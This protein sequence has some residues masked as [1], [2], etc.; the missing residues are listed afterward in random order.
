MICA[1]FLRL[2]PV[3]TANLGRPGVMDRVAEAARHGET[4]S[5]DEL[6]DCGQSEDF[7]RRFI[8]R[9]EYLLELRRA[10]ILKGAGPFA[11]LKDGMYLCNVPGEH[12]AHRVIRED[13]FYKAGLIEPEYT[14]R[15]WLAAL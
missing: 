10:G 13:P 7:A 4:P 1:I 12:E 3:V 8:Y 2:A 5:A 11:D 15:P 6:V 9:L 14:V